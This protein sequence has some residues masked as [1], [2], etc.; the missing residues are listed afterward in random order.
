MLLKSLSGR[1]RD[2]S[3]RTLEDKKK[4]EFHTLDPEEKNKIVELLL[5]ALKEKKEILLATVFGGFVKFKIFRDIDIAVFTGYN[6]AYSKV[7]EYEEELSRNLEKLIGV[8]IDVRIID[9]APPYFRIK[10]LEGITLIERENAL[11]ARLKFKSQQEI[12]D[13]KAKLHKIKF[14]S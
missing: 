13:L 6:I 5:K 11:A 1:W 10:A 12:E 4:F 8:P 14:S 7:E 3:L 2:T 9:Y